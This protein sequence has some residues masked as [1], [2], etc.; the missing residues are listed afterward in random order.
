M[1][2]RYRQNGASARI[3]LTGGKLSGESGVMP[4]IA[5]FLPTDRK[6][7]TSRTSLNLSYP[8]SIIGQMAN[9]F[10]LAGP[11]ALLSQAAAD[12]AEEPVHH[13]SAFLQDQPEFLSVYG[14]GD[15]AAGMAGKSCDLLDRHAIV[16]QKR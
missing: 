9:R 15:M 11:S 8:S 1:L 13:L 4:S 7:E 3:S 10:G 5:G 16:G 12:G 6:P 14:L 2:S